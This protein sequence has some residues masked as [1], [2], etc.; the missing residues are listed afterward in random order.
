M[1]NLQRP[2]VPSDS[3]S[4]MMICQKGVVLDECV[5]DDVVGKSIESASELEWDVLL[6]FSSSSRKIRVYV[7]G[8]RSIRIAWITNKKDPKLNFTITTS[9]ESTTQAA[10]PTRMVVV[11]RLPVSVSSSRVIVPPYRI[12]APLRLRPVMRWEQVP[13]DALQFPS[14][15]G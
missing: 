14:D 15:P 13:R 12:V 6:S 4:G 1:S 5:F 2:T 10:C 3:N 11:H 7:K 8:M 9:L